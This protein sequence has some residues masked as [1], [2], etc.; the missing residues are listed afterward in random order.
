MFLSCFWFAFLLL[1][2]LTCLHAKSLQS[3]ATLCNPMN[4]SLPGSSVHGFSRQEY[5]NG[6]PCPPLGDLP[7]P[8]IKSTYFMS[9]ALA[10]EFFTTSITW[11]A[12]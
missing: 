3:C 2:C 7:N 1:I 12:R 4:C 9:P 10:A 8:G 11:E 6:L 5:W